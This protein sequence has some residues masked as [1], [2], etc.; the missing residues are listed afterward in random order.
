M[1]KLFQFLAQFDRV[2]K[3]D[4]QS[5]K[6]VGM[7]DRQC[8]CTAQPRKNW[9]NYFKPEQH[10]HDVARKSAQARDV[11]FRWGTSGQCAFRCTWKCSCRGA[12]QIANMV[13][14]AVAEEPS[15]LLH[16]T[17]WLDQTLC[18]L[19][20]K[21]SPRRTVFAPAGRIDLKHPKANDF[22]FWSAVGS[23][24]CRTWSTWFCAFWSS[25]Q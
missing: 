11:T 18:L 23:N 1:S 13:V 14:L 20:Y 21:A 7:P 10:L 2:L 19:C 9:W 3:L 22:F 17:T 6:E 16:V 8:L 4:D 25:G 24:F 12:T 5:A 15:I